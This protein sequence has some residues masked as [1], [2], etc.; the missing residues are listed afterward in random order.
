MP[1]FPAR[2]HVLLARK[3]SLA[4]VL[5]RGPAKYVCSLLWDRAEDSITVGQWF[6]G[7]IYE[8]R[9]DLSPDGRHLIYFA[10]DGHWRS[11]ARGAWTAISRAP[12]LKARVLFAKGDCWHGG[13]LFT[14]DRSYWLNDGYGHELL[15]DSD[16][17]QRDRTFVP[18]QGFGGECPGV[19]YPRLLRDG[20]TLVERIVAGPQEAVTVFEKPI[21]RG[22]ILRKLAHEQVGAPP[23][24]GC[25][26][27]EHELQGTEPPALRRLPDWEWADLD[28]GA[29]V[30][31]EHG[32]LWR[33]HLGEHGPG[34]AVLVRDFNAMTFAAIAAPY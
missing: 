32:C 34:K 9:A 26:W 16:E 33:A 31:A 28:R 27:D 25:Y 30:W 5:R 24:K 14:G 17:V 23:G 29:L 1:R 10:M 19:Y 13:G 6:T 12:W 18:T 15:R 22:W 11:E 8:R 4:L 3:S 7:R 20:W 21:A 2:L